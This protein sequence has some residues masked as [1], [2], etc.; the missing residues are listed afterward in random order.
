[1]YRH[2]R[3]KFPFPA[4]RTERK[5]E[6]W[7]S[8]KAKSFPPYPAVYSAGILAKLLRIRVPYNSEGVRSLALACDLFFIR[9]AKMER[10][11]KFNDLSPEPIAL[12]QAYF[13]AR[14]ICARNTE[15]SP[16]RFR[17][18]PPTGGG[19]LIERNN[20]NN[21]FDVYPYV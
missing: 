18:Y 12:H 2:G 6:Q 21:E 8:F 7:P 10:S 1:V 13:A 9:G 17:D 14:E 15:I 11:S 5:E 4:V 19:I 3:R 16:R 20:S